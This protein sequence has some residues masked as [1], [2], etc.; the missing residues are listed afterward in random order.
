MARGS[1]ASSS[2]HGPG[3]RATRWPMHISAGWLIDILLTMGTDRDRKIIEMP[4]PELSRVFTAVRPIYTALSTTTI[5]STI[6]AG[7][8]W[9]SSASMASPRR[10]TSSF[11]PIPKQ[12]K[13]ETLE[14]FLTKEMRSRYYNPEW[15]QGMMKEGCAGARTI[16]NKFF[17]FAWGWQVTDPE[18]MRDWMWNE[19]TD[20]YFRD[21]YRI[22]VT[23]W[24]HDD[25][26]APAMINMAGI[27]LTAANKGFWKAN[28]ETIREL[29]NTLGTMVVRYGPSCSANV[30]GNKDTIAFSKV[31]MNPEL[32]H[33]YTRAMTVGSCG[34]WLRRSERGAA[35]IISSVVRRWWR[36][37]VCEEA[38][39]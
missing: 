14:H 17:E 22:G 13:V 24:F 27:L 2:K 38:V 25:R 15:I 37:F 21:K 20:I 26:Q 16:S 3:N 32:A 23:K 10:T 31:W 19:V 33:A 34:K 12:S 30:C 7:S 36:S 39:L 28:P 5:T 8:L 29:A 9:R 6:S 1:V 4:S 35:W 18:I 11:M